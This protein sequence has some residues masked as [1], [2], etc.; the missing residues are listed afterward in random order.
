M[1]RSPDEAQES[2]VFPEAFFVTRRLRVADPRSDFA[3]GKKHW[4]WILGRFHS[5]FWV[6]LSFYTTMRRAEP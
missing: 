1:S 2:I 5:L 3:A 6:K 4:E